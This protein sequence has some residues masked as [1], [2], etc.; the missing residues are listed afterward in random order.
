MVF[1][2]DELE[3]TVLRGSAPPGTYVRGPALYAQ[4]D[5]TTLVPPGWSGAVDETGNLLLRRDA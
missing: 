4:A 1:A 3:A 2:G 5:A